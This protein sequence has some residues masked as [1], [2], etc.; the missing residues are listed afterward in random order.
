MRF[1]NVLK[2]IT[3]KYTLL[4]LRLGNF[5]NLLANIYYI[6][7]SHS[8]DVAIHNSHF[9]GCD[10]KHKI[11]QGRISW[12]Q[13]EGHGQEVVSLIRGAKPTLIR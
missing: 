8:A 3:F 2:I 12:L 13:D 11:T 1:W 10:L 4:L 5:W 7:R 9:L 6:I